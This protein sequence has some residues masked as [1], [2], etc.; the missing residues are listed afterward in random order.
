MHVVPPLRGLFIDIGLNYH[1]GVSQVLLNLARHRHPAHL[2][3]DI[4]CLEPALSMMIPTLGALGVPVHEFGQDGLLRPAWRMRRV[5]R[6]RQIEVVVATSFR[7]YLVAKLATSGSRIPVIFW[8]HTINQ[9]TT[10]RAKAAIFHLLSR[11][12]TLLHISQAA[13]KTNRPQGHLGRDAVIYNGVEPPES[14]SE[15]LPCEPSRR[16]E[17]ELS[18]DDIVLG[19]VATFEPYKDHRTLLDGFNR[20]A[21]HKPNLRLVL[22]G[23]GTLQDEMKTYAASLEC[24]SSIRFLGPREDARSLLGLMDLY[25]HVSPEEGFGLA[26][27]EAMLANRPVVAARS[28]ALPELIDHGHTG[29]LFEARDPAD[30]ERQ[31]MRLLNDPAWA[32]RLALAAGQSSRTRFP[33]EPFA[34]EVV[35]LLREEVRVRSS[36]TLLRRHS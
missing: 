33:P 21:A 25:V 26:V 16:A 36:P 17:F 3:M 8:I 24:G 12:D 29:L 9:L 5:L 6:E 4:G 14:R 15:W 7:S 31:V 28:Y 23:Q 20:L 35:D 2:R 18:P 19:Y 32:H 30:F 1:G 11:R 27:V 34:A 10:R 13:M 22:I